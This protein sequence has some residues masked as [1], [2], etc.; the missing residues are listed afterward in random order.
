[1]KI[2]NK[3]KD[4]VRKFN[5]LEVGE[6]FEFSNQVFMKIGTFTCIDMENSRVADIRALE[7]VR[8][9]KASLIIED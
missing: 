9:L 5:D 3:T 4:D 2:I 7:L 1:M 6:V 8:V